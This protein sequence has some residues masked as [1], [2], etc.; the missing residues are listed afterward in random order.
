MRATESQLIDRF[1]ELEYTER[2]KRL[3]SVQT[4]TEGT[5]QKRTSTSMCMTNQ[6]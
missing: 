4:E 1:G 5:C 3:Q 2:L 6:S